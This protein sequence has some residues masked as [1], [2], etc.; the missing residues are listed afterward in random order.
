MD[1]PVKPIE[2]GFEREWIDVPLDVLHASKSLPPTMKLS[3]KYQQIRSSIEAVGLVEPLVVIQHSTVPGHFAILDGH[4]RAEALRDLGTT[5]AKCLIAKDDESYT[6]NKCVNRL[7][8]VQEPLLAF[9]EKVR[10]VIYPRRRTTYLLANLGIAVPFLP[11]RRNLC[12]RFARPRIA[13]RDVLNNAHDVSALFVRVENYRGNF[14]LSKELVRF[15]PA[16]TTNE[17]IPVSVAADA[18]HFDRAL[19]SDSLNVLRDFLMD[20]TVSHTRIH[21]SDRLDRDHYNVARIVIHAAS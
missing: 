16:L 15:E 3:V 5:R 19:Q 13:T 1:K 20:F 4:L 6:Y 11:E 2:C 8:V 14:C 12:Q 7:A 10:Y 18:P 9:F 21:D 17:R